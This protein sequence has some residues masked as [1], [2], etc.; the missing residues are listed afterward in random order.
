MNAQT[1]AWIDGSPR[2]W[3]RWLLI[4]G[5]IAIALAAAA[6]VGV[7]WQ[8]AS[9]PPPQAGIVQSQWSHDAGAAWL[10]QE[11]R[12]SGRARID[13]VSVSAWAN[14]ARHPMPA[15]RP[16]AWSIAA[17]PPRIDGPP[18]Q[19]I[20]DEAFGWPSLSMRCT[21]ETGPNQMMRPSSGIISSRPHP[22]DPYRPIVLPVQP[23]WPGLAVNTAAYAIVLWPAVMLCVFAAR[24]LLTLKRRRRVRRGR[25]PQCGYDLKATFDQGCSEC[26][27]RR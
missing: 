10:Y 25:C 22:Y 2:H 14:T 27:W 7:A 6:N 26:G 1:A 19:R 11:R 17:Q 24:R 4:V 9:H 21:L 3:R 8:L 5:M 18:G 16:P 12:D 15:T 13:A 23:I 20:T